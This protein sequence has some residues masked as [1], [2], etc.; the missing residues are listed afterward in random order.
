MRRFHHRR[1]TGVYKEKK[2][3]RINP[4]RFVLQFTPFDQHKE[5]MIE[6]V[7]VAAQQGE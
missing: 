6:E 1:C 3:S 7:H 4:E 2:N 5:I